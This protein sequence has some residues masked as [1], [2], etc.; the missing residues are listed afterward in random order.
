MHSVT[1]QRLQG[2]NEQLWAL[3]FRDTWEN[4]KYNKTP[5]PHHRVRERSEKVNAQ[6]YI[7]TAYQKYTR[8]NE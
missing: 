1:A 7:F 5:G 8:A 4:L 3:C 6:I 2:Q